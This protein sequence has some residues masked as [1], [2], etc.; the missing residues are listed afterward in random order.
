[1][2]THLFEEDTRSK[3]KLAV[4]SALFAAEGLFSF[5]VVFFLKVDHFFYILIQKFFVLSLLL[6]SSE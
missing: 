3:D 1:M 2:N 5:S 4:C 6:Q